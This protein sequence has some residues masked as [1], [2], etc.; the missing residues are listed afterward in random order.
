MLSLVLR[1]RAHNW[2]VDPCKLSGSWSDLGGLELV[3][4]EGVLR[5]LVVSSD[6]AG[7]ALREERCNGAR[8]SFLLFLRLV[9][10]L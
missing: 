4:L 8:L 5:Q 1:R 6:V 2:L 7:V 3:L 9:V 10:F